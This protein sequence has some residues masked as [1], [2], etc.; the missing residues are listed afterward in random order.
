MT[1]E[2]N[3]A[4]DKRMQQSD[5]DGFNQAIDAIVQNVRL[6]C[7][8]AVATPDFRMGQICLK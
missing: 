1:N 5:L 3:E 8:R 6:P 2:I 7:G 4:A